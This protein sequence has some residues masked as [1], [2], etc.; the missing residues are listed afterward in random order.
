MKLRLILIVLSLL[1]FLSASAGG[2]FSY[3]S[4]KK[5]SFQEAERK[6]AVRLTLIN[7]NISSFLSENV[8]PVKTLARMEMFHKLLTNP[9]QAAQK[10]SEDIL[11]L[12][13]SSLAVDVCYI[14]NSEGTTVAT[15]NRNAPDSFMN[16]NFGFRPYFTNAIQG[17]GATYLALGTTSGKRGGYYSYPIFDKSKKNILGVAVI[18]TSIELIEKELVPLDDKQR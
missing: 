4:L 18:K 15:S 10:G 17:E 13:Q 3:N 14:M 5:V 11:D 16:K 7:K 6:A 9:D 12:F 8:K 1:A 2:L